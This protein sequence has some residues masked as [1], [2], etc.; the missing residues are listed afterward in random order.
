MQKISQGGM[1]MSVEAILDTIDDMLERAWGVPFSGGK[2]VV[3]SD[4][5]RDLIDEIRLNLPT[6]IKQA[7]AIAADRNEILSAA[8]KEA[9]GIVKRAEEK[10]KALIAEEE[11]YRQAK[12]KADEMQNAA[13]IKSKEMRQ[14]AFAYSEE[15]LRRVEEVTADCLTKIKETQQEIKNTK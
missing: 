5:I 15:M 1:K 6:E 12:E 3:N 10:A 8:R 7:K 14:A 11:I 4:K 13:Q 2:C 9:D